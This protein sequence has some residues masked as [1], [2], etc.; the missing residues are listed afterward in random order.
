MEDNRPQVI[1][2]NT[3]PTQGFNQSIDKA[4]SEL[5]NAAK[6][7]RRKAE[8]DRK[9]T[10][11]IKREMNEHRSLMFF[12]VAIMIIMLGAII[13]DIASEK[14]TADHELMK[15]IDELQVKLCSGKA[16]P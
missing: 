11:E 9:K 6:E 14:V 7:D 16:C 8:E 10:Q 5:V 1:T 2:G 12:G 3:Q 13:V 15:S 4:I